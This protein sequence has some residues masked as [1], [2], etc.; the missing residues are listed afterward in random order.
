MF[1]L[2]VKFLS[3]KQASEEREKGDKE[4]DSIE[5]PN[6]QRG[7]GKGEEG[8]VGKTNPVDKSLDK[9]KLD[10]LTRYENKV[11]FFF[12]EVEQGIKHFY[13]TLVFSRTLFFFTSLVLIL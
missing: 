9:K 6:A 7:R 13:V 8:R 11:V 12:K 1:A 3:L 10:R 2:H 4:R 5:E